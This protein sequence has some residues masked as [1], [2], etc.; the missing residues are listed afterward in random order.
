MQPLDLLEDS[1]FPV[2]LPVELARVLEL[3][4]PA[5]LRLA[6]LYITARQH[7]ARQRVI[8]DHAH[9]VRAAEREQLVFD[10]SKEDVV[11]RLGAV[12]SDQAELVASPERLAE[13]PGRIVRAA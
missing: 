13:L 7:A 8:S 4:S 1:V 5:G 3:E 12:V 6:L 11:S 9:A 2:A 10:H